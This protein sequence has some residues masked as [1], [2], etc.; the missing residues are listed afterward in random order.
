MR[1]LNA[2][3]FGLI[4]SFSF[5]GIARGQVQ[6]TVT[7]L[8]RGVGGT[9]GYATGINDS[10]QIVGWAETSGGS[11]QT[12]LYSDGFAQSIGTLSAGPN[13]PS[14]SINNRG[15]VVTELTT[16]AGQT[17]AVLYSGSGSPLDL[18]TLGGPSSWVGGINDSEQIVGE[19]QTLAGNYDAFLYSGGSMQD[20]NTPTEASCINDLGQIAGYNHESNGIH[21][22][23]YS[24]GSAQYLGSIDWW[25]AKSAIWHQQQRANRWVCPKRER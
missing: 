18:G 23:L 9:V 17:H 7:D 19:S 2:L 10:A 20:L 4:V 24:G 15:Q 25:N 21:A 8:G 1:K 16:T 22:F 5:A 14:S 12:F 3:L 13:P 11:Y 6:Y